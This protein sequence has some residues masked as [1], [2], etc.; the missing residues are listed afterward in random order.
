MADGLTHVLLGWVAVELISIKYPWAMK[1]R[2]LVLVG[3][4]LPDI[5][6]FAVLM[7]ETG[8]NELYY[9]FMPLHSIVGSLLLVGIL[10]MIF[11]EEYRKRVFLLLTAGV[12]THLAADYFIIFL[13]GKVPL[14]F[15]F[16]FQK[17]GYDLFLQAGRG[18]LVVAAATAV[19]V[20]VLR[21]RYIKRKMRNL[22]EE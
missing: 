4:I 13:D 8:A 14:F 17:V 9:L 20:T 6:N 10:T 19:I 18:F 7:G 1:Y 16:T 22:L 5:G 2:A 3:A 11:K 15:P 21:R 12:A